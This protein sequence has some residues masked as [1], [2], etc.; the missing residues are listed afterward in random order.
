MEKNAIKTG[1]EA[2]MPCVSHLIVKRAF[3]YIGRAEQAENKQW[4]NPFGVCPA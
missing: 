2:A 4:S 3:H 1:N